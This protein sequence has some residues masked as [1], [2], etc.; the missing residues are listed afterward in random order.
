M[1]AS[2]A[3]A[4]VYTGVSGGYFKSHD[5]ESWGG[6]VHAGY[7]FSAKTASFHQGIELEICGLS[8]RGHATESGSMP[9]DGKIFFLTNKS[10]LK[11]TQVPVMINYRLWG[12]FDQSLPITWYAGA[13]VGFQWMRAKNHVVSSLKD[14]GGTPAD[15]CATISSTP[16]TCSPVYDKTRNQTIFTGQLFAG[17]GYDM[18]DALSATVGTRIFMSQSHTW[19]DG[20][21]VGS[22]VHMG[23]FQVG[24]E[25]GLNYAY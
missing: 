14:T 19:D 2:V 12:K 18:T 11:L 6:G 20:R 16:A 21:I 10:T 15:V 9:K 24:V 5:V 1:A 22:P 7:D 23:P 13:G 4:H 8:G 17:L 3:S 25:L